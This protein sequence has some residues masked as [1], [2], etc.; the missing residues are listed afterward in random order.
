MKS[1]IA[2]L[3][4]LLD[5][6][7]R[8]NP[9]VKGLDRDLET[10][11][12]RFKNEGYGFLTVALLALDEA[13][14]VGLSS[15]KFTCPA[16][17]KPV[18]G[19]TIPRFL[20]GM[21]C[22]VFEP[23]S[24][25]LK[26]NVDF[27]VLTSIRELLRLFK[28]IQM[29]TD[30]I[31]KLHQ[32]AVTEFFRCDDLAKQV[33]LPDRL[34]HHIGRVSK[35]ILNGLSSKVVHEGIF[36]HGPGA[37]FEG[38][39]SNQKWSELTKS[40]KNADFDLSL[41]GY[42]LFE[43]GLSDLSERPQEDPS[44]DLTTFKYGASSSKAK[45][46]TVPKSTTS[47]RTITVEPLLNQFRQQG[48]MT[49]LRSSINECGVLSKS[50]DLT[51][52]SHNQKLALE[53][54]LLDNWATIDLKS[55]SDLLSVKLVQAVFSHHS[56]FF[57]YMMDCRSTG[58]ECSLKATQDLGKFAGMGNA[59]TFPVQSIC[60]TVTC[61]AAIL[62]A[63]G[64]SPSYWNVRRAARHIRVFGDDIIIS[65]RYAHQCVDWLH[66][67]GLKVNVKKS[68]LKGNFK[69]SCGVDA[70]RGVDI[71]PM[72]LQQRPDSTEA[73]PELIK[74][75]VSLCNQSWLRGLYSFSNSLK[76]IVE[77]RLRKRLPLVSSRSGALGWISR[78][79][80]MEPHKW[81]RR[82]HQFCTRTS[83]FVPLKRKDR[84][85]GMP[86]LLKF[87]HKPRSKIKVYDDRYSSR[88]L[89]L[90]HIFPLQEDVDHLSS[91][92]IRYKNRICARWVP[93]R[94]YATD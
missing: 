32:E 66:A 74:N 28:K 91:T 18:N 54:S 24:G 85:S 49:L 89:H 71:T 35:Y 65:T 7:S 26:D 27:G 34:E 14:L 13:L 19:G 92:Q 31:D 21:F 78:I 16:N 64:Y 59:L 12:W 29:S 60:F 3:K 39:S 10:I 77:D 11:E 20:S 33:I 2:L 79:D 38:L 6:F 81:D 50:I 22:E 30:E 15:S 51:D 5:D 53:G 84:L 72:Y 43:V 68:F 61:I 75:Y 69:E 70:F 90:S 86:A 73:T 80:A 48:L 41:Y 8:L 4:S 47:R 93:T 63:Q 82:T 52:Q 55:A 88:D 45:L 62:D 1:P 76:E 42:D 67:V 9:D 40:V 94:V 83:V 57:G 56:Q 23:L 46:I 25:I 44:T 36:R 17:F 58:V 37:V 87:F